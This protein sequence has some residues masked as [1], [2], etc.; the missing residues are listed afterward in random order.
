MCFPGHGSASGGSF[1]EETLLQPTCRLKTYSLPEIGRSCHQNPLEFVKDAF[2]GGELACR[3][4]DIGRIKNK[5]ASDEFVKRKTSASTRTCRGIVR[6][7]PTGVK[8]IPVTRDFF[9]V[10]QSAKAR[11]RSEDM[12]GVH[13]GNQ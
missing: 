5:R 9:F 11:Q 3:H 6:K 12:D 4:A 13:P 10:Q 8:R 2:R 7:P 1:L